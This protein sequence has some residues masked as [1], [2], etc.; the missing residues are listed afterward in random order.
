RRCGR[1]LRYRGSPADAV[2]ARG[3]C[4][5]KKRRTR[6]GIALVVVGALGAVAAACTPKGNLAGEPLKAT[7][8]AEAFEGVQCSAVRPQT[9]PDLMAWDPGSRANLNR[10]RRRG[11]VAVRYQAKG[12]NVDL[13]LLSNCI[14]TTATYEFSPYSA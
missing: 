11:I 6:S 9:E 2:G 4:E 13:E 3:G 12:C 5:M 10:L 7:S 1:S 14:G 8:T